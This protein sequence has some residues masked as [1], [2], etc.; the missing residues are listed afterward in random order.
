MSCATTATGEVVRSI[1]RLGA[2]TASVAASDAVTGARDQLDRQ[3]QRLRT[4]TDTFLVTA[5]SA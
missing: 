5:K 3:M 2:S 4:D 1:E